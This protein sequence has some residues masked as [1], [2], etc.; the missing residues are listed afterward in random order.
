[1][2]RQFNIVMPPATAEAA[3]AFTKSLDV[4]IAELEQQLTL[5]RQ[6]K[7]AVQSTFPAQS[8]FAAPVSV[9]HG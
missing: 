5:L 6:V 4:Q 7:T 2:A 3:E 1:M 9:P 8:V